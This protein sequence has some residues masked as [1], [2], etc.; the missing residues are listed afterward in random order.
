MRVRRRCSNVGVTS[1]VTG[2]QE[3]VR[4]GAPKQDA[5]VGASISQS[6]IDSDRSCGLRP[7]A[8]RAL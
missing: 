3:L 1:R 2:I 7:S 5:E 4:K 6:N 8:L